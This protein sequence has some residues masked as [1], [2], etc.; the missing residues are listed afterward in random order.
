[1]TKQTK[2]LNI[3]QNLFSEGCFVAAFNLVALSS[4]GFSNPPSYRPWFN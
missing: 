4:F 3:E 2:W 1:M